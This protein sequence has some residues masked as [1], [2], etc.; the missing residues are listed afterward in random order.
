M[1]TNY[2]QLG[3]DEPVRIVQTV[4][5]LSLFGCMLFVSS[6]PRIA[7]V[8][9]PWSAQPAFI[10]GV[11][12]T[13]TESVEMDQKKNYLANKDAKAKA[14]RDADKARHDA[15]VRKIE[16]A[17]RELAEMDRLAKGRSA[18]PGGA[19]ACQLTCTCRNR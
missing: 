18:S 5:Y 15:Q 14:V 1:P 9:L 7:T 12:V 17:K 16:L 10:D 3:F 11:W 6:Y 13:A 8:R 2:D 4:N 19:G